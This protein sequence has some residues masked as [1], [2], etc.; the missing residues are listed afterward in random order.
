MGLLVNV[1]FEPTFCS[2]EIDLDSTWLWA[3]IWF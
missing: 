3:R 1:Y 2:L